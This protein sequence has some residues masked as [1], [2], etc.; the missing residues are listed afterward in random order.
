MSG[1]RTALTL[2]GLREEPSADVTLRNLM[3]ALSLTYDLRARYRVFEYEAVQEGATDCAQLFAALS[4]AEG[5]Q[6]EALLQGLR[7]R[8]GAAG[9]AGGEPPHDGL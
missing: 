7:E 2:N 1:N 4:A 5:K 6:V 9:H 8:L 3:D